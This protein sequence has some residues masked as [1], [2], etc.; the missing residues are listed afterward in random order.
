[1]NVKSLIQEKQDRISIHEC[2]STNRKCIK[3]TQ[4]NNGIAVHV[5]KTTIAFHTKDKDRTSP[6]KKESQIIAADLEDPK[7]YDF[8]QKCNFA[9]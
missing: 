5:I 9:L 1:M 6:N 7:Q 4:K 3:G 2:R 8:R